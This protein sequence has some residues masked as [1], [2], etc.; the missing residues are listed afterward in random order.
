MKKVIP[1]GFLCTYSFVD[2]VEP[3]IIPVVVMPFIYLGIYILKNYIVIII[4]IY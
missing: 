2:L 1:R 3:C 4:R